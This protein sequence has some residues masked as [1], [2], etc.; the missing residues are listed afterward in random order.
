MTDY[1]VVDPATNTVLETYPSATDAEVAAAVEASA[2]AFSAWRAR[3]VAD[4]AAALTKVAAAIRGEI[5]ELGAIAT[6]EMGKTAAEA[7]GELQI[8]ADIFDFYADQG[9][10]FIADRALPV[11]TGEATVRFEPLG[12][13]LGIMPWNYPYYQIARFAAP[14]LLLGNTVLLK[15]APACPESA[16]AFQRLLRGA[17]IPEG[18]YE[19]VL[20]TN[21]QVASVIEHPAVQG[22]SLTGSERAGRAVGEIAGRSLKKVVLELGGSDPFIVLDDADVVEAA[23]AAVVGR[24]GNAGQACT[25]AKRLIVAEA[26]Y[27]EFLAEFTNRVAALQVGDPTVAGTDI[28]PLSSEAAAV[29]IVELVED[30]VAEGARVVV[31]GP[32]RPATGAFVQPTVLVDVPESA[33]AYREEVFGPVAVVHKVADDEE[34]VRLANDTPY[35]LGSA[36]FGTDP[37][38]LREIADRLEVGMVAINHSSRTQA[39]LPFGGVKASGIGRELGEFGLHEFV[40]VKLLRTV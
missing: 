4:R 39:D 8:V 1:R 21:E 26:V 33:R 19:T 9:P 31:G 13:L 37:E 32:A 30:A 12:V 25:A 35:G 27:D 20:A 15:P 7:R 5:D 3:P 40:N 2:T 6:R 18:V 29:S 34:A 14:N 24:M 23:K 28:G 10:G 11:A 22:V 16:Y 38:R 36:V 17:G